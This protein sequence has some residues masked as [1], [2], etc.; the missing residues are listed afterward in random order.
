MHL[1][2]TTLLILSLSLSTLAIPSSNGPEG[3]AQHHLA[4]SAESQ[5]SD[6]YAPGNEW[7]P[8]KGRCYPSGPA[9]AYDLEAYDCETGEPLPSR[10]EMV[11]AERRAK[12]EI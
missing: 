2:V 5:N 1:T 11:E 8:K 6:P 3:E 4:E 9:F 12:G 7:N 10:W